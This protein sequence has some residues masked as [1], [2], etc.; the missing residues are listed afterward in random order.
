MMILIVAIQIIPELSNSV[1]FTI[2]RK[3]S[4]RREK[5]KITLQRITKRQISSRL[6]FWFMYWYNRNVQIILFSLANICK[7]LYVLFLYQFKPQRANPL[8]I[9]MAHSGRQPALLVSV[10]S[11]E[12]TVSALQLYAC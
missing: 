6:F 10:P 8:V 3:S 12:Q 1:S 9:F 7:Q 5:K 4:I 11:P 2:L